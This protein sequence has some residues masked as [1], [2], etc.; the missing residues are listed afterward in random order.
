[1][2]SLASI[3]AAICLLAIAL[4][5]FAHA[6][7]GWIENYEQAKKIAREQHKLIL[8]DFTGSDWCPFC[9]Q[10]HKEV[11]SKQAFKDY[12]SDKYVLLKVDFPRRHAQDQAIA[13][14]NEALRAKF[15]IEG[16][17]TILIMDAAGRKKG[18]LGYM[19]GGPSAFNKALSEIQ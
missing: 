14:Q 11:F 17:P 12:A 6:D 2:K 15:D 4:T 5:S 1:M 7:D 3:L 10:L 8:A 19:E 9:V 18:Q 13:T 16:F